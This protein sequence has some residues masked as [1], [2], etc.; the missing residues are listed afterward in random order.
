MKLFT[1]HLLNMQKYL[2]LKNDGLS[3]RKKSTINM[4]YSYLLFHLCR[5]LQA[6]AQ[7]MDILILLDLLMKKVS[8]LDNENSDSGRNSKVGKTFFNS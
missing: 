5:Y 2:I 7:I 6:S 3:R 1:A 8:S 4:A